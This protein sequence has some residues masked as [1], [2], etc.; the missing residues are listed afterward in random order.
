MSL[1]KGAAM[2][3]SHRHKLN[4]K[5]STEAELVGIDD[6]VPDMMWSFYF[7]R[8]QGYDV[9]HVV[10][11][12]DN[13]STILLAKNGKFSSSKRT[14][15]IK[16][17]FFFIKDL[18]DCGE[19]EVKHEGTHTMWS[20]VL[21]KPKQGKAFYV[22]RGML[23]NIP[24]QYDDDVERRLTHPKLLPTEEALP[25]V[26]ETLK[27]AVAMAGTMGRRAKPSDHRRSVLG[28]VLLRAL[29]AWLE[30]SRESSRSAA[31]LAAVPGARTRAPRLDQS[32]NPYRGVKVTWSKDTLAREA[33]KYLRRRKEIRA[34][35]GRAEWPTAGRVLA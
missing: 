13:K 7:I 10:L 18:R 32:S 24:E 11:Y 5:S 34:A 21:T 2:S 14:K 27:Q 1:G 35:G 25:I 17:R 3:F 22:M 23:M 9:S 29:L 19:V 28:E 12:Q 26:T 6:A 15:H 31:K 20:D 16:H 30:S 4:T 8:A 33:L